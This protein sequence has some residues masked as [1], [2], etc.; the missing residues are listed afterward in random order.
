M[1]ERE[2]EKQG[3]RETDRQT[4]QTNKQNDSGTKWQKQRKTPGILALDPD[5]I[6]DDAILIMLPEPLA[7]CN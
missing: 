5:L 6:H 3:G 7:T 2:N 1:S 4:R